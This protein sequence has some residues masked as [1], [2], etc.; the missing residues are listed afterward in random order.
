M[1]EMSIAQALLEVVRS[2]TPPGATVRAVR[3]LAGPMRAIEPLALRWA[4]QA[5]TDGT[6]LGGAA[7]ELD[8]PPWTLHCDACGRRFESEDLFAACACGGATPRP[9][10]GDELRVVSLTVDEPREVVP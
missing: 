2:H 3:V 6:P 7:L 8:Q 10:G 5:L 1:H 9:V 4:W